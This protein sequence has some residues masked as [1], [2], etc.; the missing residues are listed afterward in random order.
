MCFFV[1]TNVPS[2]IAFPRH[3][4]ESPWTFKLSTHLLFYCRRWLL[5][6]VVCSFFLCSPTRPCR[7]RSS[8]QRVSSA[9]F[10]YVS[11]CNWINWF[12]GEFIIR[13]RYRK[14]SSHAGAWWFSLFFVCEGSVSNQELYDGPAGKQIVVAFNWSTHQIY[15]RPCVRLSLVVEFEIRRREFLN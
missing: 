5:L 12:L 9:S 8:W 15:L 11:A 10:F 6:R 4:N 13:T 14:T 2:S 3:A 7:S 1:P